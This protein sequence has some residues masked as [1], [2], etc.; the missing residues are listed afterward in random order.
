MIP[1]QTLSMDD[2]HLFL[3]ILAFTHWV[4]DGAG[5][6]LGQTMVHRFKG[7]GLA[8]NVQDAKAAMSTYTTPAQDWH[9][10]NSSVNQRGAGGSTPAI[11]AMTQDRVRRK[12]SGKDG[13]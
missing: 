4:P 7:L 11:G 1:L 8:T 9:P 12:P 2:C 13:D 5:L 3:Q 10:Q 6:P